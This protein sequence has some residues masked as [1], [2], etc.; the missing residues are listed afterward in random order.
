MGGLQKEE[1][2]SLNINF[3]MGTET[4]L[5]TISFLALTCEVV[6]KKMLLVLLTYTYVISIMAM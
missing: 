2:C 1:P 4:N 6:T 3:L 5:P